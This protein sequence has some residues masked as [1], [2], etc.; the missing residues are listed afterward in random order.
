MSCFSVEVHRASSLSLSLQAS[1]VKE[2]GGSRHSGG[3]LKVQSFGR[4]IQE[5]SGFRKYR[6]SV[7]K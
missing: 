6:D 4:P 3:G 7:T 2:S 5:D 1:L